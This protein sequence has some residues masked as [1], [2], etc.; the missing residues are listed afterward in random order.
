MLDIPTATLRTW[1]EATGSKCPPATPAATGCIPDARW[2]SWFLHQ[3][4]G[5]L[6]AFPASSLSVS[7]YQSAEAVTSP[8]FAVADAIAELATVPLG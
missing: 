3:L 7:E 5:R 4:A 6:S 2:S 1:D 8:V